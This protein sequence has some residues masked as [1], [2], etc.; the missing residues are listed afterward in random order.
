MR[1]DNRLKEE[2]FARHFTGKDEVN[3]AFIHEDRAFT[4]GRNITVDP[5]NDLLFADEK[6]L[7]DTAELLEIDKRVCEPWNALWKA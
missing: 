7:S 4:D 2:R 1:E 3:L 5:M 6:V